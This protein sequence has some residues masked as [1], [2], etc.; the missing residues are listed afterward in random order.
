[1]DNRWKNRLENAEMAPKAAL[2]DKIAADMDAQAKTTPLFPPYLGWAAGLAAVFVT[3]A[4]VWNTS[5]R[6][7][8]SEVRPLVTRNQSELPVTGSSE[9]EGSPLQENPLAPTTDLEVN[10]TAGHSKSAD[11]PSDIP[12]PV[13]DT[14]DASRWMAMDTPALQGVYAEVY[15]SDEEYA[16]SMESTALASAE[17]PVDEEPETPLTEEIETIYPEAE[18]F[19]IKEEKKRS[20]NTRALW[21][22]VSQ[23]VGK[24]ASNIGGSTSHEPIRLAGPDF[25]IESAA[26]ELQSSPQA[27]D[28]QLTLNTA[29]LVGV[30][31]TNSLSVV[32][33]FSYNRSNFSSQATRIDGELLHFTAEKVDFESTNTFSTYDQVD[34]RGT[35]EMAVVPVLADWKITQGAFG[36]SVQGGPEVGLLLRQ[37]IRDT[38][39]GDSRTTTAGDLYRP[40][41]LRMAF[42]STVTYAVSERLQVSLQPLVEKAVTSITTSEASFRSYPLNYSA[43][44][45]LRYTIN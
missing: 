36:W 2:W 42:G 23:G 27:L 12:A 9:N 17:V 45:G 31:V 5:F 16:M 20:R 24:Y 39:S 25:S 15:S 1:M 7:D 43:F 37:Q 11:S 14:L 30:P 8:S 35:Y 18:D 26:D 34:L 40:V 22:G 33:G 4:L 19:L 21:V 38:D 6:S 32:T 10:E 41:H 28:E 13:K 44:V 29:V 3:G